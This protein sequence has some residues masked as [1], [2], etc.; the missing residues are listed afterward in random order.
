MKQHD[1]LSLNTRNTQKNTRGQVGLEAVIVTAGILVSIATLTVKLVKNQQALLREK[2][3]PWFVGKNKTSKFLPFFSLLLWA[4]T[5]VW[6][7]RS[8]A[9]DFTLIWTGEKLAPCQRLVTDFVRLTKDISNQDTFTLMVDPASQ[10]TQALQSKTNQNTIIT[11][12]CPKNSA[13]LLELTSHQTLI[14]LHYIQSAQDFD[15]QDWLRFQ[16]T[17]LTPTNSQSLQLSDVGISGVAKPIGINSTGPLTDAPILAR[18]ETNQDEITADTTPYYKKWWF[19]TIVV[20][21]AGA[22]GYGI[23]QGV[24]P[25]RQLTLEFK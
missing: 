2:E 17:I 6:P 13:D 4:L 7:G 10:S 22:L 24:K 21:S 25:H 23:Y 15:A 18:Q 19:W 16:Q 5:V 20:S 9:K 8:H 12:Q 11:V 14:A 3:K 1:P